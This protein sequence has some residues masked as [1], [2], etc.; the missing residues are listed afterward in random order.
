VTNA[1]N[2]DIATQQGDHMQ[3]VDR[4]RAFRRT[5]RTALG[6]G[7]AALL[8]F[9][10]TEPGAAT[11]SA[12]AQAA[13]TPGTG[14]AIALAYKVNPA[15]GG[16]SFGITAGESVAGHQNTGSSAQSKAVN[17]GVIGVTLAGEGCEGA[18]PTLAEEDQPQ[19]LLVSSDDEGAEAGKSATE[20]E[21]AITMEAA[22]SKRPFAEA[23]TKVAPVGEP[24]VALITG[25]TSY[26]SS[27]VVADGVREA[28]AVTQIA[29][30]R[31][32]DGAIVLGD[33]RWEAIQRSGAVNEEIASFDI[34][35]LTVGGQRIPLP[36]DAVEQLRLLEDALTAAGLQITVP[37][38]RSEEGILFVDPLKI[39]VIPSDLRDGLIL[40]PLLSALQPVR[41]AFTETLFRLGCGGDLSGLYTFPSSTA[42]TV[43]DLA[44][45]SVSGAGSLNLE[46]GG[47]QATT[48]EIAGFEFPGGELPPLTDAP[49]AP[50]L[51]TDSVGDLGGGGFEETAAPPAPQTPA[52]PT[53]PTTTPIAPI[54]DF[55]GERGGA[56]LGVGAGGLLLLLASAEGD[57]RKMRKA[58]R[59]IPVES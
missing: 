43:L 52:A 54:S 50:A 48:A 14:T 29:Q 5:R 56:L 2:V 22:A 42:V 57:R 30:L 7:C 9:V 23:V 46:L 18:P 55:T 3:A 41:E 45:G 53:A 40:G 6:V 26:A 21:G 37:Q 44:I 28:R 13:F 4:R 8:T 12:P 19:P 15:F 32:L 10:V 20:A 16:L 25:G 35:S 1:T 27:G 17:L 39:G 58:Q 24:G 31:L 33:M 59:E 34:G 49:P 11:S 51:P 36:T 47:V 38:V